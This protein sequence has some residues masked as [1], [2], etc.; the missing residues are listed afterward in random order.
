MTYMM[1]T[2]T[3]ATEDKA[4]RRRPDPPRRPDTAPAPDVLLAPAT[5]MT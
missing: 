2:C 4:T 1:T 5:I 3:C